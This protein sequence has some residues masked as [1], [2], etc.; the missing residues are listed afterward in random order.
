MVSRVGLGVWLVAL[1]GCTAGNVGRIAVKM[2]AEGAESSFGPNICSDPSVRCDGERARREAQAR[3]DHDRTVIAQGRTLTNAAVEAADAGDCATVSL[4][5]HQILALPRVQLEGGI[6]DTIFLREPEILR[7]LVAQR[8]GYEECR[9]R[10]SDCHDPAK[11][12]PPPPAPP[13][14][15]RDDCTAQRDRMFA[16]ASADASQRLQ[17]LRAIPSCSAAST[18]D[19]ARERAWGWTIT[20]A[21][22]AASG[23]CESTI[24]L[25]PQVRNLD[26]GHH[27]TTFVREPGIDQC[28]RAV[29]VYRDQRQRCVRERA[30]AMRRAQTI[31]DATARA[32]AL[33]LLR[34][35]PPVN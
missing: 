31:R 24:T 3:A 9:R 30:T 4:I 26:P 34:E 16:A 15:T 32:K 20:A 1:C 23:N 5:E 2:A 10:S 6:H 7:C 25:D 14:M 17:L 11:P 28:L 27:E 8:L 19:M 33:A 22:N 13:P 21:V 18:T 35:C 12:P 29:A